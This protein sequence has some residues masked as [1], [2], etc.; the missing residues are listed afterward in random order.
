MHLSQSSPIERS[1]LL[2]LPTLPNH[3]EETCLSVLKEV[4]TLSVL[5]S[6]S[7][8]LRD[9]VRRDIVSID[10]VVRGKNIE[11]FEI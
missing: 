2:L 5:L 1:I 7:Y 6:Y 4:Y 9:S 11:R 3:V 10:V 8:V